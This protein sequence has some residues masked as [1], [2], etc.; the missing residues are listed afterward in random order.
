M[1][2]DPS[3]L[4]KIKPSDLC[5]I[6]FSETNERVRRNEITWYLR[7]CVLALVIGIVLSSRG[8]GGWGVVTLVRMSSSD[9]KLNIHQYYKY[10]KC[11]LY[12]YWVLMINDK[13]IKRI[14]VLSSLFQE[15]NRH[16]WVEISTM[17]PSFVLPSGCLLQSP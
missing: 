2:I 14:N 15:N 6:I 4:S 1:P 9:P 17:T 11:I 3:F 7:W 13:T 5:N 8:R 12:L 10:W 16:W